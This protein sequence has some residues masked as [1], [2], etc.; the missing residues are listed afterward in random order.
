MV[1]TPFTAETPSTGTRRQRTA[2]LGAGLAG[3][4]AATRLADAGHEVHIFEARDRVGGRVWSSSWTVRGSRHVFERGA[5]FVLDGYDTLRSYCADHDLELVDTG[6]SY[7]IRQPVDR[8]GVTTDDMAE[9]GKKAAELAASATE[10][11]SVR[12]IL[13]RL[14]V[15]GAVRDALAARI[16]ISTAASIDDVTAA[17]TL[18]H[19]ASFTPGPSWRIAGGNQRLPIAMAERLKD[20]IHLNTP[21]RAVIQGETT[22]VVRTDESSEVFD[23]LVVALPFGVIRD[24][25]TLQIDLP[26]W[27]RE[28]LDR[29]V[30]GNAAKLHLLL[31]NVPD[32]SAVMSVT[33]RYWTWT[34]IEEGGGVAPILNCF[35]G[36]LSHIRNLHLEDGGAGWATRVREL[37]SDLSFDDDRASLTDWASD[38][39]SRGAY[40]AHSPQFT[41]DDAVALAAPVGRIHFAGEYIDPE[42]TGLMEGALLSGDRAATGIL[43]GSAVLA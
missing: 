13:D 17:G 40:V 15:N 26:L 30:Q 19:V 24:R 43:Q 23:S 1:S 3:L 29:V 5:E 38:P 18:D 12:Q 6:M 39:W 33:G 34:A 4:A 2:V 20:R 22:V 27:K 11:S 41:A 28:A 35:A 16:E 8:P 7:Y 14:G 25:K 36:E 32:T 21:V 10:P 9:L 42:F 37:R 31:S